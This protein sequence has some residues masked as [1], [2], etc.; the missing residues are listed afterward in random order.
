MLFKKTAKR[1]EHQ[2]EKE[3]VSRVMHINYDGSQKI[4]SI[5]DDPMI[6]AEIIEKLVQTPSVERIVY[7]QRKK[8]EYG[9]KQTLLLVEIAGIYS[10]FVKQKKVFSRL[11]MSGVSGETVQ[12]MQYLILTLLKSDPVGCFVEAKRFLRDEKIFTGEVNDVLQDLYNLLL[13]TKLIKLAEDK[14]DGFEIG[15]RSI[16][17]SVFRPVVSPDFM[18]TR[19]MAIPPIDAME[20]DSYQVTKNTYA[21]IYEQKDNIKKL[22]HLIP[23]EFSISEDKYELIELARKVL[24]EHKPK[25]EEFIDPERMRQTFFNIGRDLIIELADNKGISLKFDEIEEL[26]RILVRYTV[27]FGLVESLL[28]DPHVQD[29]VVN[30]PVGKNPIFLVHGKHDECVTNLIPA[31]EDVEGWATKFRLLSAR[32]L[33]EANPILDTELTIPGARARV[34]VI[35]RPLNPYGISYAIRRHRDKPWTLPLFVQNKMINDLAAGV[36]SFLID[37]A[38]TM[39]IAG[40]RS[41]GKTSLLGGAMVE[42]MRKFRVITVQDTLEL[43][44]EALS[45]L[46][47][48]IQD[49]KVRSA[50]LKS[51][52]EVSADEGIRTSLRLG[53][54]SLIVGEVRSKEA[55]ALYEAMRVGA[56]AN[57]VA[58]TIHGDSPY[59][60]Y[61]RVVNDLEVPR[62]SFKATD[63]IIVANPIKTA[64][65]LSR[66]RRVVSITEVRKHWEDDPLREGGFVDLFKYDAKTDTLVPTDALI[67]GDSEVIKAIGGQIKEFAGSWDAIW[68]NIQLR[69]KIKRLQVD[70]S[71]KLGINDLLE[72][73]ATV[74]LNDEFHRISE[75]VRKS[76]GYLDSKRILFDWEESLKKYIK[77]E[78]Q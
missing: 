74:Y 19:M 60:V 33:D 38:R 6:M 73:K 71:E 31:V 13:N 72:A 27:G 16:Y 5:E 67:N 54:S 57:V 35:G 68:D 25:A 51:G 61:D 39:L 53:D 15:D 58:G 52:A 77:K 24:S 78:F 66:K 59:G 43:P 30:S 65:G 3:G 69:A 26:A 18:Y 17:R 8:Y 41:S 1:G 14:L 47:F 22:Y 63:I 56:L 4:P 34:A 45:S 46:G 50:L 48:N 12:N 10:N 75:R 20:V 55:L 2:I 32:P 37:G 40:T 62:T 21:Q 64:D 42:I 70:Y 7:H 36:M 76:M 28:Q 29:I 23:P 11:A 44:T 9:Y 49:M